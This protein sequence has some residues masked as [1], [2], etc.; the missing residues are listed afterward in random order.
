MEDVTK[1][2]WKSSSLARN[3]FRKLF[4]VLPLMEMNE[5]LHFFQYKDGVINLVDSTQLPKEGQRAV[6]SYFIYLIV[7]TIS[8]LHT[9][10]S[11][12]KQSVQIQNIYTAVNTN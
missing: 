4:M 3:P 2:G 8:I 5:N 7:G 12:T 1:V 9:L 11:L 6:W 10:K